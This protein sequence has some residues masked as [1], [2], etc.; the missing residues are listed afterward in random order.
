MHEVINTFDITAAVNDCDYDCSAICKHI[1]RYHVFSA[2][3]HFFILLGESGG[4]R[5]I[6]V[7][8]D[9][10]IE[11]GKF[12]TRFQYRRAVSTQ[13]R[14]TSS[15]VILHGSL[16]TTHVVVVLLRNSLNSQSSRKNSG[17]SE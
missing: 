6:Q 11:S 12:W 3:S 15:R 1:M 4:Q 2:H 17:R 13:H 5:K 8:V 10:F 16:V 7:S 9:D 14:E